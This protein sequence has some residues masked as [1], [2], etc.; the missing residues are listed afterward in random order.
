MSDLKHIT[1]STLPY[2]L[3]VPS[4]SKPVE[5]W[6]LLCFLHGYDEA[7]DRGAIKEAVTKHGPLHPDNPP[8]VLNEFIVVA[9]QMPIAGKITVL[10]EKRSEM[11]CL[12]QF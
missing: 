1:N 6:P 8:R 4:G 2:L 12:G 9:P 3:S 10:V 5:G 11:E 7:A